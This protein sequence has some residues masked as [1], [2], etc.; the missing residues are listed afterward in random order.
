MRWCLIAGVVA[1]STAISTAA[2]ADD[3]QKADELFAT[4]QKLREQGKTKEACDAFA[5]S[6]EHNPNAIG[7]ILNVAR[8]AEEAG[9]VASAVRSFREARDRAREQSLAPQQ[10]VAEQH[11][12]TLEGR[13]PHLAVAFAEAP[14]MDT[15][16]IIDDRSVELASAGDVLVDPGSVKIVVSAPGRVPFE[17]SISIAEKE[18]KAIAIP[19]LA[20]PVTVKRTHQTIGKVMIA[21]GGAAVV[22]AVALGFV[23]RSRWRTAV[24]TCTKTADN[25]ICDTNEYSETNSAVTLGDA[26]TGVGIAGC[27][28]AGAGAAL[29]FLVPGHEDEHKLA[30]FPVIS[31]DQAGVVAVRRF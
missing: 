5:D 2:F 16:L 9:K 4:A 3:V 22:T 29:W 17:T 15:R 25:Y 26:G 12:A 28:L 14:S 1:I 6:L 23:A 30:V 8:C 10:E 20:Y 27:V 13:A 7:T 19:K 24:S 21:V 11:L 31:P 18:H